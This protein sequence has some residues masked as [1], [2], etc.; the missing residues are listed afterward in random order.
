MRRSSVEGF[1]LSIL[2]F[3]FLPFDLF[4]SLLAY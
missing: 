3:Y 1:W 2:L 4:V